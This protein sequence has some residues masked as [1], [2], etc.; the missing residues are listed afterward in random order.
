MGT[1]SH[2][3]SQ[4]DLEF[5][6]SEEKNGNLQ[7]LKALDRTAKLLSKAA[8]PVFISASNVQESDIFWH[9]FQLSM[10]YLLWGKHHVDAKFL[11]D[12]LA[13]GKIE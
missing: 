11:T 2:F 4:A 13:S 6:I 7:I 1:A 5:K 12:V 10:Q 9:Y 8:A 3:V